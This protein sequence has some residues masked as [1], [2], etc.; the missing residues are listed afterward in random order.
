MARDLVALLGTG[1]SLLGLAWLAGARVGFDPRSPDFG[2]IR[3]GNTRIDIWAGEVQIF[4][5]LY[6]STLSL[7]PKKWR[8]KLP[9]MKGWKGGME[10]GDLVSRFISYKLSP[11]ITIPLALVRGKDIMGQPINYTEWNPNNVIIS[12][13]AP[14]FIQD[15]WTVGENQ[16]L[17]PGLLAGAASHQGLSISNYKDKRR[18][19]EPPSSQSN[20]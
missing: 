15:A 20:R 19:Y 14:L 7:T 13:L 10:L 3:I 2:K 4:R 1:L 8:A 18:S 11:T 5:F 12:S 9:V 16:G 17:V 6:N